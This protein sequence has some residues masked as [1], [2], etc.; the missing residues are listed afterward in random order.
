MPN[1]ITTESNA[2][3][4]GDLMSEA[5]KKLNSMKRNL[6]LSQA[7]NIN[8]QKQISHRMA[9]YEELLSLENYMRASQSENSIT[10][11][12]AKTAK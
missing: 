6:V 3:K 4:V 9:F 2:Q 11:K 12:I 5:F 8:A 1:K 10:L 7:D